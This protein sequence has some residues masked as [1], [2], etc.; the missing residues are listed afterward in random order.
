[1]AERRALIIDDE[2]DIIAYHGTLL[3]DNGWAVES[4]NNGNDGLAL[5]DA[6]PPDLVL[7]DVMMPERGGLSTLIRLRKNP[8]LSGV[9]VVLIT[10]VQEDLTQDYEDFLGKFK[11]H[12]PDGYVEKPVEPEALLKLIDELVPA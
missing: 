1:M 12:R 3:A 9:K 7:L 6:N 11:S 2:P 8:K 4:A 5:A 10:G